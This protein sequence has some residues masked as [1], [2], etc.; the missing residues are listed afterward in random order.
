LAYLRSIRVYIGI[1]A[2]IFVA[3]AVMGYLAAGADPEFAA[4]WTKELEAL[5]WIMD[6]SP[7]MI[8]VVIFLKNL[9]ACAM[10]VLLGLGLGIMPLLV[11]TSNG[12]LLG[13]VAYGAV[14]KA[15]AL[16]VVAG[17]AP[18]GIIELPVVLT[19]IAIGFRLGHV[20]IL[21]LL[22]EDEDVSGETRKAVIFLAKWAAPLLL[23]A[24]AI[25]TFITP[26]AI[27]M[28]PVVQ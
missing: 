22:G 28:V 12:I 14:Q 3:T 10:S 18:H 2:L 9:L 20:L 21:S 27:S 25:E 16:Y 1:S 11:V 15:G 6:L 5:R 24:A 13:I 19:S 7:P 8:M 4:S 17:I 23:V 26:I